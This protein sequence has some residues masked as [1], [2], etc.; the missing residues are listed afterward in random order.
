MQK[1]RRHSLLAACIAAVLAST[2][3]QGTLNNSEYIAAP[4]QRAKRPTPSVAGLAVPPARQYTGRP[5]FRLIWGIRSCQCPASLAGLSLKL[6][7]DGPA[8]I[9]HVDSSACLQEHAAL[10]VE[11][12]SRH[13]SGDH[14]CSNNVT[15]IMGHAGEPIVSSQ[16]A[17][18]ASGPALAGTASPQASQRPEATTITKKETSAVGTPALAPAPSLI[19]KPPQTSQQLGPEREGQHGGVSAQ[20]PLGAPAGLPTSTTLQTGAPEARSGTRA[21]PGENQPHTLTPGQ[22]ALQELLNEAAAAPAEHDKGG[23]HRLPASRYAS[24]DIVGRYYD[25]WPATAPCADCYHVRA[26]TEVSADIPSS[27]HITPAESR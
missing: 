20:G 14:I 25:V 16:Q 11:R 24:Q 26:A 18:A 23:E 9:C 8:S 7:E 22:T 17:E 12:D 21:A 6:K 1:F 19:S 13:A 27:Q 4:R 5:C 15:P 10:S 3:A 2:A